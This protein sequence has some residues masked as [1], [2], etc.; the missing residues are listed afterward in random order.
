MEQETREW[1]GP[2]YWVVYV[3][4]E[5]IPKAHHVLS[6]RGCTE[7][8]AHT[9]SSTPYSVGYHHIPDSPDMPSYRCRQPESRV[10]WTL[11][12][13]AEEQCSWPREAVEISVINTQLGMI[14]WDSDY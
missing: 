14:A 4:V 13:E 12:R 6:G 3:G 10:E 11:P 5:W 8:I 2:C 7:S 1:R 9:I